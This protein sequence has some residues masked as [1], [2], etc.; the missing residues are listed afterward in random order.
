MASERMEELIIGLTGQLLRLQPDCRER[1]PQGWAGPRFQFA[2]FSP[3]DGAACWVLFILIVS[4]PRM[5]PTATHPPAFNSW[6]KPS[7]KEVFSYPS[8]DSSIA[9]SAAGGPHHMTFQWPFS[10]SQ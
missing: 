8:A 4:G 3:L 10:P 2:G 5:P 9:L 7:G 6:T 1:T